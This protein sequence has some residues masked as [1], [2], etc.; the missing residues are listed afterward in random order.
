M[1]IRY[2]FLSPIWLVLLLILF[3]ISIFNLKKRKDT[4][5]EFP[6]NEP[7]GLKTNGILQ[8][9]PKSYKYINKLALFFMI[10]SLA[11]PLEE[12]VPKDIT[13]EGIDIVIAIDVSF[14]MLAK[15]FEPNRLSAAK[16]VAKDFVK[17]RK[18]DRVGIVIYAGE[19]FPQVP[20][21][22]DRDMVLQAIDDIQYGSLIDGTAIGMGLASSIN[23]LK[24]SETLS[25]AIILLSDGKNN[26][27]DISPLDAGE[28]AKAYGIRVYTIGIG[29]EGTALSPDMDNF[30]NL[31]YQEK[32]V[33]IDE[34]TLYEIA[35]NTGGLYFRAT[36]EEKLKEIYTEIDRLEKTRFES[37]IIKLK[38]DV[39]YKFLIISLILLLIGFALR[40][41]VFKSIF[42]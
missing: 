8:L 23:R 30:G 28:L 36:S 26:R 13:K 33:Q 31:F 16:R 41:I 3:P 29:S 32:T 9:I 6:M 19:S 20:L 42:A 17:D 12:M 27:G 2:D 38:A 5:V 21:T 11:R 18:N 1:I 4:F 10:L 22:S 37:T 40:N 15:D 25:K 34:R 24:E 35:I 14:S 39:Y 7:D